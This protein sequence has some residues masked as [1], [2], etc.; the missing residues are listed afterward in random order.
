MLLRRLSTFCFWTAILS[1][2][3]PLL[4]QPQVGR[5]E[6][7]PGT[8]RNVQDLPPGRF[9]SQ[10]E[11]LPASARARA[12]A[13]L[14]NFHF[15][16][17]DLTSLQVDAAG[18]IF[19]ADDFMLAPVLLATGD[20]TAPVAET[21]AI[22]VTPF[23]ASLVFHS[24]LGAPNVLFLNFSGENVSGT[25]WNTSLG[26][27]S[28]PAVAFS[29]DGD[30]S[31][32]S[33]AEQLAVKRIWQRVSEDYAPFNIDVTT[34]RPGAFN[35]RTAHALIT[36]STDA[37]GLDNPAATAGGVGYVN[38]FGSP[39]YASY[40]PVWIYVN[41]LAFDE[42]YV[43]EAVSHE[44]GHNLGLSHDG[45]TDSNYYGGHGSGE[46]SWGPIMGTGYNRNVSQWSKGEY[47][48]SNNTQDD[49]ATIAAKISYRTDDN[50][51]TASSAT[52]L[53]ITSGTQILATTPEN[54]PTQTN[55]SNKGVLERSADADVFSFA[56]G[57]G[58]IDLTVNPW[59]MPSGVTRGGNLDVLVELYDASGA[60]VLT[61]NSAA[62]TSARLQANLAEGVYYLH[63]RNAAV[64]D[65]MS[66]TPSGYTAYAS[67]GQYFIT[68]SVV[69]SSVVIPPGAALQVTDILQTG[70]GT[71]QFTVVYSDNVGISV[72]TIDDNDIL[73]TGPNGYRRSARFVALNVSANGTPRVATYAIDPPANAIWQ[74]ADDGTYLIW[75]Q[76]NQVADTEG[77]WVGEGELGQF[78][79]VVPHAIYF[80][81]MDA[82]PGWTFEGLWQYGKPT[83]ASGGPGAG[84]TGANIIAYNLSGNYENRLP[85]MFATTPPIDCSGST[86]L[87][88]RFRRWLRLK[89]GDTAL[90]QVSTNGADWGDVWS[91][92]KPVGD[93]AWQEVQ[94]ALPSWAAGNATVR[95]RW[96]MGSGPSQNDIGWNL[97]DVQILGD[98]VF[99]TTVPGA[100]L[101]IANVTAGGSPT[102]S[103]TVTYN[104][105]SAISVAS[106]G[107][108]DLLVTGPNGYSN[109]VEFV[110]VDMQSD[111]T[112]R[113]ATYS[114]AAPGGTWDAADNGSYQIV[115]QNGEV[116]DSSNNAIPETLLGGFTV[117]ITTNPQSLVVTP[118]LLS[119]VEGTNAMFALRLAEQ[120]SADVAVTVVQTAG[121]SNIVLLSGSN[122]VFTS[123]NWS[124]PV[125]VGIVAMIDSDQRSDT[126]TF[127]CRSEGLAPVSVWITQQDLTPDPTLTVTVN[128]PLWGSVTP[129]N[130]S[131]PVGLSAEVT[132]QPA[133][134]FRFVSWIGDY[135]ATNNPL[136]VVLETNVSLEAIFGQMVTTNHA[137][138][139]WWLAAQGYTDNF[140]AAELIVGANGITLWQSYVAGLNPAD[141]SSQLRLSIERGVDET[142]PVL[143][144]TPV[145]GRLYT[146]LQSTNWTQSFSPIPNASDLP[147]GVQSF[148]NV[149]D[150]ASPV[151]YRLELRKP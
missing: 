37:N 27:N 103:F 114:V 5:R 70:V 93:S 120:P 121:S 57:T 36:R 112:P 29:V 15:T 137:T 132:A 42:S 39:T 131:Y 56:T 138:P 142:H 38:V 62:Q 77:A 84:F 26:R 65:P 17:Q 117:A 88:L 122:H 109:L 35:N 124:V 102:H 81:N 54:D 127:E 100:L 116:V 43:G 46:T 60:L 110:G 32:F 50:G 63:I 134:Y 118:T 143:R 61:N 20:S 139:H 51:N 113:T 68:G 141:P 78:Q 14:G 66:S 108:S 90:I 16:E 99:D 91:T 4:A 19:Y 97:D 80:A 11:R 111:G 125:S 48:L 45:R 98:G 12:E 28:I 49:L 74:P 10:L 146:L 92:S 75:L 149:I 82:S 135:Q 106:L 107:A 129:T 136:T 85:L 144:W 148:T 115:L 96:G 130:S 64:G 53:T 94:N 69:Q 89:N 8:F 72:S 3:L 79:V 67:L 9:R 40:R 151:F 58:P 52:A 105:D 31:T 104:D 150:R 2:G 147:S 24:R 34:E 25:E 22:A 47:Y 1:G 59:I 83:Y 128:N 76:P 133:P 7:T 55:S 126:A 101:N 23:P 41:N 18:A 44:V 21:A 123:L 119:V 86:A 145:D 30:Y 6:F 13:W 73:V 140:E 33:D 71:K 95:L 87:T